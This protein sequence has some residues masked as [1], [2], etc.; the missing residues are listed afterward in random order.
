MAL[1]FED[2]GRLEQDC[3]VEALEAIH[4]LTQTTLVDGIVLVYEASTVA[5][6]TDD[7]TRIGDR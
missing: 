6:G 3:S 2:G 4:G 7:I 5:D 1:D